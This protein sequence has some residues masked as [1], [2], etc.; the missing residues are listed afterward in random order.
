MLAKKYPVVAFDGRCQLYEEGT[1][2]L[3]DGRV[4]TCDHT[5]VVDGQHVD[6]TSSTT[7]MHDFFGSFDAEAISTRMVNS[8]NWTR[9]EYFLP[10]V[11]ALPLFLEYT[12]N[13]EDVRDAVVSL[14]QGDMIIDEVIM[15]A[16]EVGDIET[17]NADIRK[18]YR[19]HIKWTWKNGN[20]LGTELHDRIEHVLDGQLPL[21]YMRE[22]AAT[23]VE[24][25]Y[26][27]EWY[28]QELL[29]R[30]FVPY[31]TE[32]R[33]FDYSIRVCGSIDALF[34][35]PD[36]P[37]ELIMVDWKRS[38]RLW[39]RGFNGKKGKPPLEHLDD[40]NLYHYYMQQNVYKRILERNTRL[41]IV[42]M[43]LVVCHPRN[44]TYV[45]VPVPVLDQEVDAVWNHRVNRL[46]QI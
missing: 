37:N 10:A 12:G 4:V 35:H 31:R 30:G 45:L 24:Y 15:I 3:R 21:S 27:V 25:G 42:E 9:S 19:A 7:W 22:R 40:C 2:T 14:R 1:V 26:W 5:Y 6:F 43:Y 29:P 34:V 18:A 11:E 46:P 32:L 17:V 41:R 38:K 39:R 33:I 13:H 44:S 28:Q 8:P 20:Q 16:A 23:D 36:R